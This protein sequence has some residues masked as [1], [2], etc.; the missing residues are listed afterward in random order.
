MHVSLSCFLMLNRLEFPS[1]RSPHYLP[2]TSA[3]LQINNRTTIN[4][5]DV[6]SITFLSHHRRSQGPKRWWQEWAGCRKKASSQEFVRGSRTNKFK[7]LRTRIDRE[8]A[9]GVSA[10]SPARPCK[11]SHLLQI[12]TQTCARDGEKKFRVEGGRA[13]GNKIDVRIEWRVCLAAASRI[14]DWLPIFS[15]LIYQIFIDLPPNRSNCIDS[16]NFPRN[17]S[18]YKI[19]RLSWN[20]HRYNPT[21]SCFIVRTIKIFSFATEKLNRHEKSGN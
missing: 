4:S 14:R 13:G 10:L 8:K 6:I 7:I 5:F 12:Y 1:S 9:T 18:V 15:L 17:S 20:L 19:V 16:R 2:S 3:S 21:K 11:D